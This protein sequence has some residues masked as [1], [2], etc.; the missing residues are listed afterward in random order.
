MAFFTP[1]L[2]RR[3]SSNRSSQSS[4]PSATNEYVWFCGGYG[5]KDVNLLRCSFSLVAENCDAIGKEAFTE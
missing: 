4:T 3:R 2:G 5:K 1:L